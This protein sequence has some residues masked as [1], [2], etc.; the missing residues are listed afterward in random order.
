MTDA[1]QIAVGREERV[2]I[3]LVEDDFLIRLTLAESLQ[4]EGFAVVEAE[5]ADTALAFITEDDSIRALLTDLQIPGSCDGVQLAER[6]RTL[7]PGLPI[8]FITGRPD[9]IPQ[10]SRTGNEAFIAKP[11]LPS[12]VAVTLRRLMAEA[13]GDV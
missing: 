6:A 12:E 4:D 7:R 10:I 3:L 5:T 1:R 11:Y 13:S 8:V 2:R 9:K